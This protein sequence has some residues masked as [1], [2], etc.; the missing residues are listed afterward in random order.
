MITA[1]KGRE[2]KDG[3]RV[4]VYRNLH[5]DQFSIQCAKTKL[6]LAHGT[7]FNLI[8]V[9]FEVNLKGQKRVREEQKKN[10]HAFVTGI[11]TSSV[12]VFEEN[13]AYY[14]P[15][16]NPDRYNGFVIK[17]KPEIG[18]IAVRKAHF[19]DNKVFFEF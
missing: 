12:E 4:R 3:M 10:V 19:K 14:N 15:Y 2:L 9:G 8:N 7:D 5:Q 11:Y 16:N 18:L 6:V 1:Y 17:D 13:E